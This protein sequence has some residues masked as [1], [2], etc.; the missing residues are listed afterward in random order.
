MSV[1]LTPERKP[2]F[3][4]TVF[5]AGQSLRAAR[6]LRRCWSNWRKRGGRIGAHQELGRQGDQQL[7]EYSVWAQSDGAGREVLD[8]AIQ[9]SGGCSTRG[10][11]DLGG[12]LISTSQRVTIFCCVITPGDKPEE[13]LEMVLTTL[14]EMVKSG[15]NCESDWRQVCHYSVDERWF[16]PHFEKMLYD[17]A[18]LLS[19][20]EA[21]SDHARRTVWDGGSRHLYLFVARHDGPGRRV[22]FGR[23]RG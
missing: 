14:R 22:L 3:G 18:Q 12:R 8:R 7:R 17:Q 6:G 9:G 23:G 10:S 16:V 4:G 20:L 1:W 13:A 11:A 21:V 19:Y 2:F 5:S 15:M